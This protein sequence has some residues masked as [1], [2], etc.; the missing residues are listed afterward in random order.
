VR[1]IRRSFL[2]LAVITFVLGAVLTVADATGPVGSPAS[3]HGALAQAAPSRPPVQSCSSREQCTPE[4]PLNSPAPAPQ[5]L[6]LG[7]IAAGVAILVDHHRRRR[8]PW[9]TLAPFGA[10][11]EVF[12]PPIAS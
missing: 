2:L 9:D 3:G 4:A 5:M 10:L 11:S 8:S 6:S 12:R 1:T 7:F